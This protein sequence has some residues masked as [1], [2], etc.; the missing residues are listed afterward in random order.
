MAYKNDNILGKRIIILGTDTKQVNSLEQVL[1]YAGA[2]V[3]VF[4][5]LE[6][7]KQQIPSTQAQIIIFDDSG[8]NNP[9]AVVSH[10]KN[11]SP[12]G[13]PAWL[14][15]HQDFSPEQ[16]LSELKSPNAYY[17]AKTNYD[18][19][20][21]LKGLSSLMKQ[22]LPAPTENKLELSNTTADPPVAST[23]KVLIFEDDP[24]LQNILSIHLTRSKISFKFSESGQ[25]FKSLI[26]AYEPTIILLDLTLE[27]LS[28]LEV[29]E[30]IRQV[31]T[32]AKL[33]VI[34][35]TNSADEELRVKTNKLGVKDFLIKANTDFNELMTLIIQRSI[36]S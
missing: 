9:V 36:H 2:D 13:N 10:I 29:L 8:I 5:D 19:A 20:L 11:N 21:V 12:N 26:E 4:T 25:N 28:G 32:M 33:P 18:A 17:I 35:F 14:V 15:I 31:A 30:K 7:G 6:K 16:Y 27:G 23:V 1:L 24:L 3:T 34:I 22:P